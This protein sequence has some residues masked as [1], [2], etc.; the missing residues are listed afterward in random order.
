MPVE[1]RM[2]VYNNVEKAVTKINSKEKKCKK[3]KWLYEDALKIAEEKKKGKQERER[4]A[5][6]NVFKEEW[7]IGWI[8]WYYK[9]D[10]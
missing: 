6:L 8:W 1:L 7:V 10:I 3:A 9:D 2:E 4:Y 5:Q